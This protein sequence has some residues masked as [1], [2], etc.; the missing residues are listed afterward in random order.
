MSG[1]TVTI[2]QLQNEIEQLSKQLKEKMEL[3]AEIRNR[4]VRNLQTIVFDSNALSFWYY[5]VFIIVAE[6][7]NYQIICSWYHSV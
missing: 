1:E 5:I 7:W 4:E 2:Q 6:K 3:L